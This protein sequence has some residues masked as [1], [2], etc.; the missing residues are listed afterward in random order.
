GYR[1]PLAEKKIF[2]SM[3]RKGNCLDNSP[4]ESFFGLLKQEIYYGVIYT[5]FK[6]LKRA[7]K[8]WINYYNHHR[9]KTRLGCSPVQYRK[10][11]TA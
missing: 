3:S 4:M 7:I 10:R 5:S 6:R 8:E 1:K 9:I 2:Q 11:M